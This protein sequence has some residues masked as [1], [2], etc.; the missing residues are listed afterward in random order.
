MDF[1]ADLYCDKSQRLNP[2]ISPLLSD[3]LASMPPT[4]I[5]TAEFDVLRDEA[6]VYAEKLAE[7]GVEVECVRYN[8]QIHAYAHLAGSIEA[9]RKAVDDAVE[10]IKKYN[11]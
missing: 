2:Y 11:K 10:F 9:G 1:G 6:E 4:L 8:G 5:Q 3:N 7:N